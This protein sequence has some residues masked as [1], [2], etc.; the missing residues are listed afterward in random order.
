MAADRKGLTGIHARMYA[1]ELART[2]AGQR[3]KSLGVN[4]IGKIKPVT[5]PVKAGKN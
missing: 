2:D 1:S 5:D 4:P 3:L